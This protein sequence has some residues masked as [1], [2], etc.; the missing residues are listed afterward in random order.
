LEAGS[1]SAGSAAEDRVDWRLNFCTNP[2][3]EVRELA[4]PGSR[5]RLCPPPPRTT[6][7]AETV[8]FRS[9]SNAVQLI[10][11]GQRPSG[12]ARVDGGPYFL[13]RYDGMPCF[14]HVFAGGGSGPKPQ[15]PRTPKKNAPAEQNSLNKPENVHSNFAPV[16]PCGD[17]VLNCSPLAP[18][19]KN[20]TSYTKPEV[21]N[22]GY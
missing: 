11:N 17:I 1:Q 4:R 19:C 9:N 14:C 10:I 22:V 8:V 3:A 13:I 2:Y 7:A 20:T 21:H 12:S 15:A 16:P 18:L 5:S 6:H